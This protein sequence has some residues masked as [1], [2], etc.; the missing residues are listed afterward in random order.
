MSQDFNDYN[1]E[2][3]EDAYTESLIALRDQEMQQAAT[4]G[5]DELPE[6]DEQNLDGNDLPEGDEN[7]ETSDADLQVFT[8]NAARFGITVD[9]EEFKGKKLSGEDYQAELEKRIT[10]KHLSSLDPLAAAA[11]KAGVSPQEY[12]HK[13]AELAQEMNMPIGDL[14][15]QEAF[16]RMWK[17]EYE[18]ETLPQTEKEAIAHVKKLTDEYIARVGANVIDKLG[19]AR[20]GRIKSAMDG[21]GSNLAKTQEERVQ[22]YVQQHKA[23]FDAFFATPKVQE[24][25]Q[26]GGV[27]KYE[28][29]NEQAAFEKYSKEMLS[30]NPKT[31]ATVLYEKLGTDAN[32]LLDVVRLKYLH[33]TGKL[34]NIAAKAVGK[35][36]GELDDFA[37]PAAGAGGKSKGKFVDTSKPHRSM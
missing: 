18:S 13:H 34:K 16:E 17:Q 32:F 3:P 23:D 4:E 21:L 1:D 5:Q 8:K 27:M 28:G 31:N 36:W 11:I 29:K 22:Q 25:I 7:N 10:E 35:A 6:G 26:K 19:T 14:G 24:Y 12:Y 33:D 20:Q 9:T 37:Q 2:S 30:L 15:K